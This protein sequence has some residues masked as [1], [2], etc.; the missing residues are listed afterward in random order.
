MHIWVWRWRSLVE[1]SSL[2]LVVSRRCGYKNGS[3][4]KTKVT[5]FC[6][7]LQNLAH[8]ASWWLCQRCLVLL[9]GHGI[10]QPAPLGHE[11]SLVH[12]WVRR[13]RWLLSSRRCIVLGFPGAPPCNCTNKLALVRLLLFS[14]SPSHT[15]NLALV[16]FLSV[17]FVC[18]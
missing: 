1:S 9:S 14:F 5:P 2:G 12:M 11:V 15:N 8:S 16:R 6:F 4:A 17:V 10:M 13:R 7:A 3:G 18:H